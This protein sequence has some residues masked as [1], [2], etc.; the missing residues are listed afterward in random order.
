VSPREWVKLRRFLREAKAYAEMN[1]RA[2]RL[3]VTAP[4]DCPH[5][6]MEGD[7]PDDARRMPPPSARLTTFATFSRRR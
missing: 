7:G 2:W 5:A 4:P 3:P 6:E 1:V